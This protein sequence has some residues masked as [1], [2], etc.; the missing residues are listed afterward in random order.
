MADQELHSLYNPSWWS[1]ALRRE[2]DDTL[3]EQAPIGEDSACTHARVY[4]KREHLD[5]M[6]SAKGCVEMTQFLNGDTPDAYRW[7][8]AQRL[9]ICSMPHFIEA[10]QRAEKVAEELWHPI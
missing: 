2:T 9:H 10:L 3:V 4:F 5:V 7:E 1:P 6:Y 8:N